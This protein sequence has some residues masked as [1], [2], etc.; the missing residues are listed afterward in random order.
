ML[1]TTGCSFF[2]SGTAVFDAT[3]DFTMTSCCVDAR[4]AVGTNDVAEAAPDAGAGAKVE[5]L[6]LFELRAFI[7]FFNSL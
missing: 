2:T 3:A 6:L 5:E 4:T 1:L 7:A